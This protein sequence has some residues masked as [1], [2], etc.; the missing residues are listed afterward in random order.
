MASFMEADSF[1][2]ESVIA[3]TKDTQAAHL[4]ELFDSLIAQNGP[5]L[6]RLAAGYTN[7]AADRDDL[8]QEMV[9]AIWRSLPQFRGE[10][11]ARTYLFR[12][13]HNRGIAHRVS[14]ASIQTVDTEDLLV[15]DP[16][17]DPERQLDAQQQRQTL[18]NAVRKLPLVYRDVITLALEGLTYVE[19]AQVLGVSE[20]N[21]GTRLN[22]AR[23]ALRDA[24]KELPEKPR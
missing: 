21:V 11:S 5:A 18:L 12:I 24:L 2:A 4:E 9:L 23:A 17:P 20:A 3:L 8:F 15:R 1:A 6:F 7:S 13:A 22:R 19:M 14:R 16:S 10:S